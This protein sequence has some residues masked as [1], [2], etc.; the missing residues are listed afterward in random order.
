MGNEKRGRTDRSEDRRIDS[1]RVAKGEWEGG[2]E[3]L[4]ARRAAIGWGPVGVG[5]AIA[6]LWYGPYFVHLVQT[7]FLDVRIIMGT[8]RGRVLPGGESIGDPA[9]AFLLLLGRSE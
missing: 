7:G 6:L 1:E 3:K 2:W 9:G 8:V 5:V 4:F